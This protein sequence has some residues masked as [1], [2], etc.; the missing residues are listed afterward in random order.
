MAEHPE[1]GEKLLPT[2]WRAC[3]T[4]YGRRSSRSSKSTIHRRKPVAPV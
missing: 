2:I 1:T 3:R 4:S